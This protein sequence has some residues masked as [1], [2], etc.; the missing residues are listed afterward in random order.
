MP[1]LNPPIRHPELVSG[2]IVPSTRS[3]DVEASHAVWIANSIMGLA[4]QLTMKRVQDDGVGGNLGVIATVT[5]TVARADGYRSAS[6]EL[7][8]LSP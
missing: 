8:A 7:N 4:E 1:S 2:P 5:A 3:L 6:W